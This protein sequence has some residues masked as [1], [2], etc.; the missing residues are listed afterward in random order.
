MK[1]LLNDISKLEGE[2]GKS[3]DL[4]KAESDLLQMVAAVL[5]AQGIPDLFKEGDMESVKGIF[6]DLVTSKDK[7]ILDY[8]ESAKVYYSSIAKDIDANM[9]ILQI[10]GIVA[11]KLTEEQLNKMEPKEIDRILEN[12]RKNNDKSFELQY[13]LQQDSKYRKQYLEPSK[14]LMEERMKDTLGSFAKK[15]NDALETKK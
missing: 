10:N 12:I 6:T 4:K 1:S 15:L 11:K 8:G 14:K 7:I 9:D 2:T 5:L 3:E 13:I